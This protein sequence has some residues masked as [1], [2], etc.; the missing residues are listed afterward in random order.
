VGGRLVAAAHANQNRDRNPYLRSI[1][2]IQLSCALLALACSGCALHIHRNQAPPPG[3]KYTA[4]RSAAP[5]FQVK[6]AYPVTLSAMPL[7]TTRH[8]DVLQL[9]FPSSGHNGHPDN[10]VE[11][12][13]FRSHGAGPKKLV[14]VMPIWGTSDYPP[15][16]ISSGYAA[17]DGEDTHVIWI[18]GTAPMF[19]WTELSSVPTED[20]F[21]ALA[22]DSAERYR[23]AVVDMRRLLDWAETQPEIDASRIAFVGFS[24]SA[25][26]T[27]TLLGNEPRIAAAVIM[28]GAANFADVFSTCGNRAGEVRDH[29]MRSFGWS[30]ER[31]RMFFQGLFGPADPMRFPGHYD[32]DHILMIDAMFDDCMPESARAA[33]WEVTGHPERIT[34]LFRHRSAFYS[35]TPLGLNFSRRRIYAFLDHA[36]DPSYERSLPRSR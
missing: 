3:F 16:K 9:S 24:M 5:E 33:L 28:M 18:Y 29:V 34:L 11:G 8:H 21:V 15:E 25:L 12:Q 13:Y 30:V 10:L 6:D 20:G 7:A 32:P 36:L 27:A 2:F 35:L 1:T 23:S 31:Y 22:K 14:I 19:P 4:P 26:V 17:H